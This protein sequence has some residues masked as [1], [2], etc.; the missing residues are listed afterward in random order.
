LLVELSGRRVVVTGASRG[1]G[2]ALARHFAAA[3]ADVALVARSAQALEKLAADLGGKAYPADLANRADRD[4]LI[5]R[6][7]AD[8]PVDVLVN[9]A[10]VDHTG[11]FLSLGTDEIDSLLEV[12]LHAPIQLSRQVLPGMVERGR[13]HIVNI[14][15][16]AGSMTGP[17]IVLYAAS[18]AGLSHF[19]AGLREEFRGMAI[20]STLVEVGIVPT[21]MSGNLREYGP[22]ARC[23]ERYEK[24]GLLVDV[25]SDDLAA[26]IVTAV[27]RDRRHV[28]RPRRALPYPLLA[29]APRRINELILTGVDHH[30]K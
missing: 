30:S 10:G 7:E 15:S 5:A 12:N 13:G 18:K 28:R 25:D 29:E 22:S 26:A 24:L 1:I 14:S 8:G 3:G 20:G 23:V 19:T 21:D 16:L 6:I 9:N 27:Q 17:G 2:E 11:A 4:G